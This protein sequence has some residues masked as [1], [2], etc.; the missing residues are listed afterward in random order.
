MFDG[1]GVTEKVDVYAFAVLLW[2]MFTNEVPWSHVPSPMQIIYFV[3]VLHQ[4][5]PIP[6]DCPPPLKELIAACWAD[7]PDLRPDFHTILKSLRAEHGRLMESAGSMAAP[8]DDVESSDGSATVEGS[9]SSDGGG[10]VVACGQQ[11]W[12]PQGRSVGSSRPTSPAGSLSKSPFE[13]V[14]LS[15]FSS[16]VSEPPGPRP[17]G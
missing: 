4:R 5:L 11:V 1:H 7:Q 16:G 17:D 15:P 2:E 13:D 9:S 12:E 10:A 3:G 8:A 14:A 6:D